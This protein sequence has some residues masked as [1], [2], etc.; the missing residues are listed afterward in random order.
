[1]YGKIENTVS[2]AILIC[3]Y[4][5]KWLP[6]FLV[7][8]FFFRYGFFSPNIIR[9]CMKISFLFDIQIISKYILAVIDS[10]KKS[11]FTS[12]KKESFYNRSFIRI[13][14]CFDFW[15]YLSSSFFYVLDERFYKVPLLF[16]K[17]LVLL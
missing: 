2:C 12:H 17:D 5:D 6:I 1:M 8:N 11:Y 4:C 9:Y 7:H 16:L 15:S 14:M 13:L 10:F 3:V